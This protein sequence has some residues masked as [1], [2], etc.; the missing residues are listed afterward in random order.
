MT[1]PPPRH[2]VVTDAN[3][4]I[5][6]IHVARL[7]FCGDLSDYDFVVPDHV[8]EE[9]TREQQRAVLD[10]AVA[11]GNLRI[12]SITDPT[13]LSEFAELTAVLGRGEAA[14]VVL[15]AMHGWNVLSDEKGRFRRELEARIGTGRLMGTA[16]L[17]VMAIRA[18][19]ISVTEADADKALLEQRR[20][21]MPFASFREL[22]S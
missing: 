18:G 20:F 2:V 22:V 1:V 17:F 21:R 9:I 12:A 11:Q 6:L 16:D 10:R 14:C 19:M 3:I 5:N 8:R 15:A 7:H 13:G 4:P